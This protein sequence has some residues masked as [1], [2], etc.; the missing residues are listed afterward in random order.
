MSASRQLLPLFL[1]FGLAAP[2]ASAALLLRGTEFVYDT[3]LDLTWVRDAN[4]AST[5][6]YTP[7]GFM[8]W[9][10][11]TAWAAQLQFGGYDDW[12]LPSTLV[13]DATC[14]DGPATG[15]NCS[16]SEMGHLFHVEGISTATPGPFLNLSPE[17]YWSSTEDG[18]TNA[19]GFTF[20]P[21]GQRQ[22]S[23]IK[24]F[25][26]SPQASWAVRDGDVSVPA[27][28]TLV[29]LIISMS[30]AIRRRG[31]CLMGVRTHR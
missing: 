13:P 9:D 14:E 21:T 4:L 28:G 15:D 11:A 6:G 20:G 3:H 5:S 23:D 26:R 25:A 29:L 19:L 30:I 31:S 2:P 17:G 1:L 22:H 7:G 12:R 24:D 16:G 27:P 10:S 18:S 8:G